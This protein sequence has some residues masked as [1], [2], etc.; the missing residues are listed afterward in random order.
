MISTL[1]PLAD[2]VASLTANQYDPTTI[3]QSIGGMAM[4]RAKRSGRNPQTGA[5]TSTRYGLAMVFDTNIE[6]LATSKSLPL[7]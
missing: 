6:P 1:A 5:R 2:A 7:Y 3:V 4:R